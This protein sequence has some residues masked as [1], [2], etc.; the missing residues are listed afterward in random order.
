M[1]G[2]GDPRTIAAFAAVRGAD[3]AADLA[4]RARIR[5]RCSSSRCS[6]AARSGTGNLGALLLGTSFFGLRARQLALPHAGVGLLRAASA[7]L[8]IAPG[9][10]ASAVAAIVAARYTDRVDPR[11]F[12][13]PGALISAA[14]GVWLATQVGTEPAFLAEWLPATA[15]DGRRRRA[16]LRDDRRGLRA[17][18]RPGAARDRE[19]DERDDASARRG[20]RRRDPDRDPRPGAGSGFLRRGLVGDGGGPR[21]AR[22]R[23]P[24]SATSIGRG[25]PRGSQHGAARSAGAGRS[26]PN[27]KRR[28]L[29]AR[30]R[31]VATR[32]RGRRSECSAASIAT[33]RSV[34][35]RPLTASSSSQIS[36][37]SLAASSACGL[38]QV[39]VGRDEPDVLVGL[40]HAEQLVAERAAD[41][42]REPGAGPPA[43]A[44]R[45]AA[46]VAALGGPVR[47]AQQVVRGVDLRHPALRLAPAA[48]VGMP[49][50]GQPPV[51][52]RDLLRRRGGRQSEHA[53]RLHPAYC[54]GSSH[55]SA[56]S[57]ELG[58]IIL[59]RTASAAPLRRRGARTARRRAPLF[60]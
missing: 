15:A 37:R 45:A 58:V 54:G 11:R 9:P 47:G 59:C 53:V 18:P 34:C 22:R 39:V 25:D 27:A 50:L 17:R 16:R 35:T 40:E 30:T 10:L 48:A 32:R 20:A 1:W 26:S 31:S 44:G 43:G 19:R 2:W 41:R 33:K 29:R 3:A 8:A 57:H 56:R 42:R 12:I 4:L 21:A 46:G 14:S 55:R 24:R 28:P 5:R 23:H 13:L 49:F 7:G 6:A 52:R 38:A 36:R 60:P 51:R